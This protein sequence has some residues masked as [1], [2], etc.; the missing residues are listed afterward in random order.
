[1]GDRVK[2]STRTKLA[3]MAAMTSSDHKLLQTK[4]PVEQEV[5]SG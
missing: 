4:A 1:M 5:E 3:A 2:Q